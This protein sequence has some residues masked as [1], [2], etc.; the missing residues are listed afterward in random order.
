MREI[1]IPGENFTGKADFHRKEVHEFLASNPC[2]KKKK[3]NFS[4]SSMFMQ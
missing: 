3:Q 1:M 2:N 4:V